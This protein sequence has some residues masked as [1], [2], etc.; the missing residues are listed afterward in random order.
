M[1]TYLISI[2]TDTVANIGTATS[3]IIGDLS[4]IWELIIGILLAVSVVGILIRM[5]WHK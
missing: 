4:P 1:F 5:F 3:G 2:P